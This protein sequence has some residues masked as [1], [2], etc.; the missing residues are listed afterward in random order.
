MKLA[1][2]HIPKTA[3][4]SLNHAIGLNFEKDEVL[5]DVYEPYFWK[6]DFKVDHFKFIAGHV[7]YR[8]IDRIGFDFFTVLRDPYDRALSVYYYWRQ[9]AEREGREQSGI[10]LAGKYSLSEF[11]DFC[12]CYD[13]LEDFKNRQVWQLAS[14]HHLDARSKLY[15]RTNDPSS[16]AMQNL[17]NAAVVGFQ[18]NLGVCCDLLEEKFGLKIELTRHNTTESRKAVDD[19][20]IDEKNKLRQ[21]LD[22]ELDFYESAKARFG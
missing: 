22:L 3:G 4:T 10:Q 1:H 17:A 16:V 21:W 8:I 19:L 13:L 18:D 11:L 12:D 20:P 6:N 9:L 15:Q 14:S 7:G 5:R 2:L